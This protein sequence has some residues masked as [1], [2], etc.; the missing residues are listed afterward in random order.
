MASRITRTL[1]TVFVLFVVVVF[2]LFFGQ[3]QGTGSGDVAEVAGERIRSDVYEIFRDQTERGLASL[4]DSLPRRDRQQF[5]DSQTLDSLI[6]RSIYA[7]DAEELGLGVTD[8]ELRSSL[9]TDPR[10]Q[11]DGTFDRALVEEFAAEGVGLSVADFLEETRRDL[12]VQKFQRA[13]ASPVR[14]SRADARFELMQSGAERSLRYTVSKAA[15]FRAEVALDP[16][17]AKALVEKDE[18]RVRAVYDA[19][20]SEFQQA[21]QVHAKHILLTGDDGETRAKRAVERL[22]AGEPFDKLA[23]E[24]SEDP[25]TTSL[26]GDLG[27]FPRGI[28][29][30]ELDAALFE[31]LALGKHSAPIRSE[32]GWHVVRVEEKRPA[33]ERSFEEVSEDLARDILTGERAAELAREQAGR[34]LAAARS[35]GDLAAAAQAEG[36]TLQT[37]PRFKRS[38]PAVPGLGPVEGLVEAAFALTASAPVGANVMQAG[39]DYYA[40]A[41]GESHERPGPEIEAELDGEIERQTSKERDRTASLWYRARRR[42]LEEGGDLRIFPIDER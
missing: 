1:M 25:A 33:Q 19:R 35:S 28:M 32:R 27:W 10:F 11:R 16:G 20:R 36:V 12:M 31:Q 8:A 23:R 2:A 22:D 38:D 5:V 29:S 6:R 3:Q 37:S 15:D 26:G 17:A 14:V 18:A 30:P 41:L 13:V 42:E 21:E 39:S 9:Q 4:L 34:V 7:R 24:L 40:I